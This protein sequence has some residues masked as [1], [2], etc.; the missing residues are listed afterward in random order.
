M[1]TVKEQIFDLIQKENALNN[2]CGFT[3]NQI[4]DLLDMQRLSNISFIHEML[5]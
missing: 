5:C 3:T 4:A 2:N 1:K